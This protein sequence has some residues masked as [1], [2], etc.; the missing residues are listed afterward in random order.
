[1]LEYS[2]KWNVLSVFIS[3]SF[4]SN[5]PEI[6]ELFHLFVFTFLL[7]SVGNAFVKYYS[8]VTRNSGT[9]SSARA[10]HEYKISWDPVK[11][12]D[13]FKITVME[14]NYEGFQQRRFTKALWKFEYLM[15]VYWCAM[16]FRIKLQLS[17]D[18]SKSTTAKKK[19]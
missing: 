17:I 11:T 9:R 5:M 10:I 13:V 4:C 15:K 8:K 7:L 1:M 19:M 16:I 3:Y 6:E 14:Y 2:V 18:L 12:R